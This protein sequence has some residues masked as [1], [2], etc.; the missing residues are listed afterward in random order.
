MRNESKEGV[1]AC[2]QLLGTWADIELH[3]V[4]ELISRKLVSGECQ[5]LAQVYLKRG[6]LVPRH[7]HK[8]EQLVYVLEGALKVRI[9]QENLIVRE[10]QVLRIP[11]GVP[12]QMEA[13]ADTFELD[14]LSFG[15]EER[16][17]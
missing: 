5:T 4:T 14:L 11:V 3:K 7:S 15:R 13:L 16:V 8:S 12:H 10:G 1:F 2:G 17:V 9:D 6:A